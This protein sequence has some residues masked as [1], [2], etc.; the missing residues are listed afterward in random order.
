MAY[1]FWGI[2][3]YAWGQLAVGQGD[4]YFDIFDCRVR[5]CVYCESVVGYDPLHVVAHIF[6]SKEH[7]FGRMAADLN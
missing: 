1:G 3:G 5:V 4:L 6:H 7:I 2:L